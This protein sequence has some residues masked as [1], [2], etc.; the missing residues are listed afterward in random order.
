VNNQ[1]YAPD[2]AAFEYYDSMIESGP[3]LPADVSVV[4][5]TFRRREVLALAVRSVRAQSVA[6]REIIVVDDCSGP[7]FDDVL[8]SLSGEARIVRLTHNQGPAAARNAGVQNARSTFVAFLDSDDAWAPDKLERQ[9]AYLAAHPDCDGV[10]TGVIVATSSEQRPETLGKPPRLT[11]QHILRQREV[12]TSSLM[13][14]RATFLR[15][16]GFDSRIV[17]SEDY[18]LSI[19]LVAGGANIDFLPEHLTTLRREDHGHISRDWQRVMH[20]QW[21]VAWKHRPLLVRELGR[22]GFVRKLL[23]DV[24]HA[25]GKSRAWSARAMRVAAAPFANRQ[26]VSRKLRPVADER[27]RES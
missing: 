15:A 2:P 1:R 22:R 24:N 21:Q 12:V 23:S 18:E 16:G 19:R 13:I 27:D 25:A 7:A 17:S 8:E 9:L 6:P 5:P 14:R 26:G 3:S 4:I 11:L 10:H 20:G